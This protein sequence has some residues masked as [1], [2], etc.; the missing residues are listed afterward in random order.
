[1]RPSLRQIITFAVFLFLST[2]ILGFYSCSSAKSL[3]RGVVTPQG[4]YERKAHDTDWL[5]AGRGPLGCFDITV[6]AGGGIADI[7]PVRAAD[8]HLDITEHLI[9]PAC[10]DCIL[11][12][13]FMP[14]YGGL[15]AT[16]TL[17]NPFPP[18]ITM[19]GYDVRLVVLSSWQVQFPSGRTSDLLMNPDGFTDI[20]KSEKF[21]TD[22]SPYVQFGDHSNGYTIPSGE[23]QTKEMRLYSEEGYVTFQVIL[24]VSWK[25]AFF[26]ETGD[27]PG[28]SHCKEAYC[29]DT[30]LIGVFIPGNEGVMINIDVYDW[31]DDANDARIFVEAPTMLATLLEL[32]LVEKEATDFASFTGFV[33]NEGGILFAENPLLIKVIDPFIKKDGTSPV[34]YQL[35]WFNT[36]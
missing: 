4:D 22:I 26:L 31:Q 32:D 24:D 17:K 11:F 15:A 28:L 3:D 12:G 19:N 16:V 2:T 35:V 10:E 9:P 13:E 34:A 5:E 23:S 25:P 7:V 8:F 14:V 36:E 30:S 6:P 29:I 21:L 27:P 33:R 18:F 20:Y 1:M